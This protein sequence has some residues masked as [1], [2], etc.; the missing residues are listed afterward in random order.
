MFHLE[1]DDT[2]D[3]LHEALGL[4]E[5][6]AEEIVK[7]VRQHEK[8]PQKISNTMKWACFTEQLNNINER[9][10]ALY[11]IG[12]D[13]MMNSMAN[14]MRRKFKMFRRMMEDDSDC[15]CE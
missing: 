11:V 10:F 1:V 9:V 7:E 8:P 2:K 13:G 15:G 14:D 5:D 6:R 3:C 12:G 4:T